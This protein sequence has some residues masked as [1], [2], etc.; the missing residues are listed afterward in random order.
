MLEGGSNFYTTR[1]RQ[2]SLGGG[3]ILL[4][5]PNNA[6]AYAAGQVWG[7]NGAD[8]RILLP[9]FPAL[10]ADAAFTSWDNVSFMIVQSRGGADPIFSQPNM[11]VRRG[12]FTTVHADQD[13]L[14]LNDADIAE[15]LWSTT[16]FIIPSMVAGAGASSSL[17]SNAGI[18][19]RRQSVVTIQPVAQRDTLMPGIRLGIYIFMPGAYTPLAAAT[20]RLIQPVASY[21]AKVY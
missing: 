9:A 16:G 11:V 6:I 5:R 12:A 19:G 4:T 13:L 8:A 18:T 10:P 17:N 20:L 3:D 1:Q 15:T 14:A 21:T 2:V 7:N